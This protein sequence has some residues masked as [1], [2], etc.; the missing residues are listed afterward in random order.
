MS[1]VLGAWIR[2]RACQREQLVGEC[3][4]ALDVAECDERLADADERPGFAAD[5]AEAAA[6]SDA[7]L[8]RRERSRFVSGCVDEEPAELVERV[9]SSRR[10]RRDPPR[11]SMPRRGELVHSATSP[12]RPSSWPAAVSARARAVSSVAAPPSTA[13]IRRV[14][15]ARCACESQNQPRA[16]ASRSAPSSSSSS[17]QP[18]ERR[19]KVVV[20]PLEPCRPLDLVLEASCVRLL[21]ECGEEVGH[22]GRGSPRSLACVDEQ[23][24]CEL[25]DRLEEEKAI[26]ADG[27]QQAQ[28]DQRGQR[29]EVGVADLLGRLERESA[30]ED[31]EAREE[32]TALLVE[33]VV[34]PRDR[35]PQCALTLRCVARASGE[36][37]QSSIESLEQRLRSEELGPGGREL[38]RERKAVQAP[39]DRGHGLV[40]RDLA[41]DRARA[42][43]EQCRGVGR[44]QWIEGV[45]VLARE[46]ERASTRREDAQPG[47]AREERSDG[48]RCVEDV[49]EVVEQQQDVLSLQ[50]AGQAVAGADGLCD[51]RLD[52]LGFARARRAAPR[53]PRRETCR[54]APPR[55]AARSVSFPVP[56]GPVMVTSRVSLVRSA[57]TSASSRSRPTS[58]LDASGRFVASS[59]LSA[60]KSPAPS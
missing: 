7:L 13:S 49:L 54:R 14:P 48:R 10:R 19:A 12:S 32:P 20:I 46:V 16:P 5:V 18:V 53:T 51:L 42:L 9:R 41:A 34:A 38:D 55:P 25:A 33:E 4:G 24:R 44:R 21:R 56:P 11:P 30:G 36:E 40:G 23:L 22:A 27:L 17:A 29:L 26:V 43:D 58:G 60:G 47:C 28:V 37:R 2:L 59:V 31:R 15:S 6:E 1:E 8:E 50:K 52:E 35:R 39:A 3:F 57:T 45:L